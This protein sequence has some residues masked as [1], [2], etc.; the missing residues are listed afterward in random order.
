[1]QINAPE[2]YI[3]GIIILGFYNCSKFH[4]WR[5]LQLKRLTFKHFK[6]FTCWRA[7][8]LVNLKTVQSH[9]HHF[10]YKLGGFTVSFTSNI[11]AKLIWNAC[12]PYD[13]TFNLGRQDFPFFLLPPC[14]NCRYQICCLVFHTMLKHLMCDIANSASCTRNI[15]LSFLFFV[16]LPWELPGFSM[17]DS[18][19]EVWTPFPRHGRSQGV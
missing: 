10:L 9:Y 6:Y 5:Q 14:Q 19:Y 16:E 8:C 12:C 1:M 13:Q 17:E 4:F 11:A 18:K 3:L 2:Y 7:L 15:N